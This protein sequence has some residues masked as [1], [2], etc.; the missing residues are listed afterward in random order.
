MSRTQ[1]AP[2]TRRPILPL[3]FASV[4]FFGVIECASRASAIVLIDDFNH[5]NIT[6]ATP[7]NFNSAI[8]VSDG[9]GTI[10]YTANQYGV[11]G[12]GTI[13]NGTDDTGARRLLA[14]KST[15]DGTQPSVTTLSIGGGQLSIT[16]AGTAATTKH[17]MIAWDTTSTDTPIGG[18]LNVD[19]S[20]STLSNIAR[21]VPP[22]FSNARLGGASNGGLLH[23]AS[24]IWLQGITNSLD[25]NT[26]VKLGVLV[27]NS[28]FAYWSVTGSILSSLVTNFGPDLYIPFSGGP[29]T[30]S[31]SVS[32]IGGF[33]T[34]SSY[35]GS[36]ESIFANAR[37]IVLDVSGTGTG[38]LSINS[39]YAFTPEPA[40]V[41]MW[42]AFALLGFARM[43]RRKGPCDAELGHF[44]A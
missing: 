43:G 9:Q 10:E 22:D 39:I 24:G 23:D 31:G 25:A 38:T 12:T 16:L 5:S 15:G 13:G 8:I 33:T 1:S 36:I 18:T 28:E 26:V 19:G 4:A 37:A 34:N 7:N 30:G 44:R 21:V 32:D 17:A 3:I 41:V 11:L 20:N 42:S 40:S 14:G 35:V 29:F 27:S 6:T 2:G